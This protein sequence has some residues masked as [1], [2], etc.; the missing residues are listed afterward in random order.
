MLLAGRGDAAARENGRVDKKCKKS[1][2][3]T[4]EPIVERFE[5]NHGSIRTKC[6]GTHTELRR[7]GENSAPTSHHLFTRFCFSLRASWNGGHRYKNLRAFPISLSTSP[8]VVVV[9][10]DVVVAAAA[11]NIWI[12]KAAGPSTGKMFQM[13]F[14]CPLPLVLVLTVGWVEEYDYQ[15]DVI[16]R[17]STANS[18]T[19]CLF[20]YRVLCTILALLSFKL[21]WFTLMRS[22]RRHR[23][24]HKQRNE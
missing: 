3:D 7:D 23:Q 17:H 2:R 12:C 24:N 20:I 11:H 10:E 18:S 21:E 19:G 1:Y 22:F 15:H 16:L 5:K 14:F 4:V 8:K 13:G 6:I 9:V